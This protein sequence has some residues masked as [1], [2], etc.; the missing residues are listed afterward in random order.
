MMWMSLSRTL[1]APWAMAHL[2]MARNV[3]PVGLRC[4]SD[5]ARGSGEEVA[6]RGAGVREGKRRYRLAGTMPGH[7]AITIGS[8]LTR[9]LDDAV[10]RH[11]EPKLRNPRPCVQTRLDE[12]IEAPGRVGHLHGEHDIRHRRKLLA[13]GDRTRPKH[14]EIRLRLGTRLNDHGVLR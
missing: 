13:V 1:K 8:R 4:Q 12:A 14:E 2:R 5:R 11:A 9:D 6:H 7:A 10:R 3:P